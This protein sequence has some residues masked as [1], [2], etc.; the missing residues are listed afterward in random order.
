MNTDYKI[1]KYQFKY[2]NE[3]FERK[4]ELYLAKILYYTKLIIGGSD[5]ED[6]NI[7]KSYRIPISFAQ[8]INYDVPIKSSLSNNEAYILGKK[9]WD[10]FLFYLDYDFD[11]PSYH[12]YSPGFTPKRKLY[13]G[14]I[15]N[16][17][18]MLDNDDFRKWLGHQ[19][20]IIFHNGQKNDNINI[21]DDGITLF[22]WITNRLN[23]EYN[24]F[25]KKFSELFR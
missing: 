22:N 17:K 9:I 1:R 5:D 23:P 6:N 15:K 3:N 13:S 16:Y 4:K 11:K 10:E 8:N 18:R 12:K 14:Q 24:F 19:I 20:S 7:N 2:N 25:D 21:A